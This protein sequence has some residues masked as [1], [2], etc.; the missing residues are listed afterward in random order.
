[1][2][3]YPHGSQIQYGV[4]SLDEHTVFIILKLPSHVGYRWLCDCRLT[5]VTVLW[6]L[7]SHVTDAWAHV[8]VCRSRDPGGRWQIPVKWMISCEQS[9]YIE[10]PNSWLESNVTGLKTNHHREYI[11]IHRNIDPELDNFHHVENF[12]NQQFVKKNIF[13]CFLNTTKFTLHHLKF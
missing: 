1:M 7:T 10:G 5:P 4:S 3:N 11:N 13:F 12:C 8:I 6:G 9:S 2:K